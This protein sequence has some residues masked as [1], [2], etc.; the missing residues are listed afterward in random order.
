MSAELARLGARS[1]IT[2]RALAQVLEDLDKLQS[3]PQAKSRSSI[4]R[5]HVA[6]ITDPESLLPLLGEWQVQKTGGGTLTV[7]FVWPAAVLS[8]MCKRSAG[9]SELLLQTLHRRPPT[10]DHPY[11]IVVYCDEITPGNALK[12]DNRRKTWAFYWS[13]ADAWLQTAL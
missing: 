10:P 1:F 2:Q 13:I 11:R 6:A 12:P 8:L 5:S 9:F 3:L 4:K 7:P